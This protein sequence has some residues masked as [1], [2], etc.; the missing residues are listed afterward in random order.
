[1]KIVDY[2]KLLK[3]FWE[4]RLVCTLTSCEADMYYYLLKQCDLGNWANPFKLPTKKCEIELDFTRKTISNVR[5]SLQQKGFI[6]F[7]P[8]KVRGEVAEYEIAG[9]DAFT[10][11]TQTETQKG[12][13]SETQK[14]TQT[15]TQKGTQTETQKE[16]TKENAP[17]TPIKENK[18]EN[19]KETADAVEK[20]E[21]SPF[22]SISERREEF[23]EKLQPYV[24]K[25]GQKLT[26]DFAA[27]WTCV[28]KDDTRMRF[29]KEA[30]FSLAGRLAT[31][32]KNELR[33]KGNTVLSVTQKEKQYEIDWNRVIRWFNK[34]GLVE[35]K[36]LTDKRKL[37]YISMYETHG[38]DGLVAFSENVKTSDYLLG[39]TDRG[40]KR[41]FDYVFEEKNFVKIIEGSY[42]NFKSISNGNKLRKE[43][44]V[45]K[46]ESKAAYESGF[47]SSNGQPRD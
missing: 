40:P 46:Y 19:L 13:Q 18:K 43:S 12:T 32:S 25:Y 21:L 22:T 15:E 34:L 24:S 31:W 35:V 20:A 2:S 16:K 36:C 5:N 47:G 17:H 38:K 37:A 42:K 14:G 41:D 26:G 29:E 7:K 6:N 1:M 28:G 44:G 4:K 9:L 23:L 8:S 45:P 30:K 3:S 33:F 39:K 10:T 27:Y 11:E